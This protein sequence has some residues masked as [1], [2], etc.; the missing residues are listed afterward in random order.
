M[1]IY[2]DAGT[3][4]LGKD[5]DAYVIPVLGG[6]ADDVA[7]VGDQSGQSAERHPIRGDRQ[8]SRPDPGGRECAG[9]RQAAWRVRRRPCD[10][11]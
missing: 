4:E 5:G 3:G 1:D 2:H 8:Q 11:P 6:S 10:R 9:Q 7:T